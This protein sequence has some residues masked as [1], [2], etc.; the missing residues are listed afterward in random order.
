[1]AD[2]SSEDEDTEMVDADSDSDEDKMSM[3]QGSFVKV[4]PNPEDPNSELLPEDESDEPDI[5]DVNVLAWDAPVSPLHVAIL[6]ARI[7]VIET[8]V[9]S[10]GADVLLPVK[11]FHEYNKSSPRGA[12]LTLSLAAKLMEPDSSQV[13]GH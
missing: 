1:M 5:Y 7:P 6:C 12:I 10:H 2:A 11:L 4:K 9:E 8:L 13:C 3:T